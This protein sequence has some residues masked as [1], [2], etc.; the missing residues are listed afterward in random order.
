MVEAS[1]LAVFFF[2]PEIVEKMA[3]A[4]LAEPPSIAAAL[5][6]ALEII[7]LSGLACYL[8]EQALSDLEIL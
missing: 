4:S 5:P 1:P 2:P 7:P 3:L 6:N 8:P